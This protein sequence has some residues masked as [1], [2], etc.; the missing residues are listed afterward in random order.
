MNTTGLPK[1][2]CVDDEK[3]VLD[4]LSLHLRRRH[5]VFTAQSGAEGLEIL[6]REPTMAVVLS[7]MRMPGMDGA[8]F[9]AQAREVSPNTVRLLLT[10]QSDME[11]AI[12][13]IN[14]GQIFRFLS[15]PCPA[16]T[17]MAAVEAATE[18][19]RLI[20]AERVL[21]EETLHGSIKAMT[22]IL[23][24]SNPIAFGRATRI[25][26]LVSE[27]A[28]KLAAKDPW[29]VEVAAMLSQLGTMILPAETAEKLYLG[30]LLSSEE[31]AMATRAP[32]VTEQLVR[33]IPRLD[34]VADILAAHVRKRKSNDSVAANERAAQVELM[35][36]L[37]RAALDFDILESQGNGGSLALDTMRSRLDRYEP[38]IVEALAELRGNDAPRVGIREVSLAVLTVGMVLVDDVKMQNGMLLV[39]RGYEVTQSFLERVRNLKPGTVKEPLR[40]VL[41]GAGKPGVQA[42]GA[43]KP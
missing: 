8:A 18:Q 25:K 42:A 6:R 12:A 21:L 7:D 26:Q 31:Q 29:Q 11:S 4:G 36:Q 38:R 43:G 28:G 24:L 27:L 5:Q 13:A 35:A 34:I 2:L 23:A 9:L 39:A 33:N 14:Q 17:V 32:V 1:I 37:L 15:K 20:T 22:D 16:Q 3:A 19:N 10:G 30:H 41:R 40:V